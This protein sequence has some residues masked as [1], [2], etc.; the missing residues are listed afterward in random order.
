[1]DKPLPIDPDKLAFLE[2]DDARQER[3]LQDQLGGND[4]DADDPEPK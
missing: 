3:E 4:P 1:M 2:W